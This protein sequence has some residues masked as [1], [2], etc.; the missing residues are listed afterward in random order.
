MHHSDVALG[1]V[2]P[3]RTLQLG[4]WWGDKRE[5]MVLKAEDIVRE[6]ESA[7]WQVTG[8]GESIGDGRDGPVRVTTRNIEIG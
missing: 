3:G 1:L 4:H 8:G 2:R 6:I 7:G 5:Q